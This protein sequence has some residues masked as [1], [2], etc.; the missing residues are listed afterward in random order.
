MLKKKTLIVGALTLI[1]LSSLVVLAFAERAP[2]GNPLNHRFQRML[3]DASV[4]TGVDINADETLTMVRGRAAF[5]FAPIQGFERV[6]A[7][8]LPDGVDM[9][10]AYISKRRNLPTGFYTIR[11]TADQVRLGDITAKVQFI[12]QDG[13]VAEEVPARIRVNSLTVPT[14]APERVVIVNSTRLSNNLN[15]VE[16]DQFWI[17]C[18]NGMIICFE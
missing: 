13:S 10:F 11:A 18:S 3:I 12:A 14:Q 7:L 5:V 6:P 9:A 16:A 4:Q 15:K 8:S 1:L 2:R 17:I